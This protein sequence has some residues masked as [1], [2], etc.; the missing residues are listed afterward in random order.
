MTFITVTGGGT[1][2]GRKDLGPLTFISGGGL[3]PHF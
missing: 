1:G 2:G 3:Y